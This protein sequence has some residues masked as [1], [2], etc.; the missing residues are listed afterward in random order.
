MIDLLLWQWT[1]TANIHTVFFTGRHAITSSTNLNGNL[2]GAVILWN[3]DAIKGH[4][5]RETVDAD[6]FA[7]S[8]T[9]SVLLAE[10]TDNV[11]LLAGTAFPFLNAPA[12]QS[13][14]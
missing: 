12:I 14:G 6:L 4:H 7:V 3:T 11:R 9:S 5:G 10:S 13:D 1:V 8:L 2:S